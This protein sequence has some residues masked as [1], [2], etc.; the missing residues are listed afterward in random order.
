MSHR[1]LFLA[2]HA[3]VLE[4]DFDLSL[5]EVE[6]RRQLDAPLAAEVVIGAELFLERHQL[7]AAERRAVSFGA[8][9]RRSVVT[10]T[11]AVINHVT[12]KMQL[13]RHYV[14]SSYVKATSY[15]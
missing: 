8:Q 4:P 1:R 5:A 13:E 15:I 12:L 2:L 11:L 6:R 14:E 7:T 10:R 9:R 3:P